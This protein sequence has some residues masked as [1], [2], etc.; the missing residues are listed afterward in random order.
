MEIYD[1][2]VEYTRSSVRPDGSILDI[3]AHREDGLL[4]V[5]LSPNKAERSV[6]HALSADD[7]RLLLAHLQDPQTQEVLGL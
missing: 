1:N 5:A 4:Y 3:C 6:A 7:A 2:N